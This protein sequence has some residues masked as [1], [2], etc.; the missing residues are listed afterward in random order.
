ME[1]KI[2]SAIRDGSFSTRNMIKYLDHRDWMGYQF[3]AVICSSFT[4]RTIKMPKEV[5]A[6]KKELLKKYEK[7][8]KAGDAK[9][10]ELIEKE[11]V[12]N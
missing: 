7:E 1:G 12:K 10:V 8:I 2:S 6:R 4:A 5:A 9:T 11:L 3:Y